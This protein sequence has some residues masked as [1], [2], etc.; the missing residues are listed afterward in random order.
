[1]NVK[2]IKAV[3]PNKMG[4]AAFLFLRFLNILYFN[5]PLLYNSNYGEVGFYHY[6]FSVKSKQPIN[7]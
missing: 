3:V 4:A 6:G 5:L 2:Y 1:M 7:R